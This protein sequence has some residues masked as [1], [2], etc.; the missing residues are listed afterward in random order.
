MREVELRKEVVLLA[1]RE[2]VRGEVE[3]GYQERVSELE[4][5]LVGVRARLLV[6]GDGMGSSKEGRQDR[7]G[8]GKGG[9]NR[10]GGSS[11]NR[12]I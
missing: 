2:Q 8:S 9:N 10:E 7:E 4:R 5:E 6:G 12:V 3:A 11:S 1:E